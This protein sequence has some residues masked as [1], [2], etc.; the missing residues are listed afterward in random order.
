MRYSWIA[1]ACSMIF[2]VDGRLLIMVFIANELKLKIGPPAHQIA[3]NPNINV[4]IMDLVCHVVYTGHI[5]GFLKATHRKFNFSSYRIYTVHTG[6]GGG[7]AVDFD[8]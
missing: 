7:G 3:T 6:G 8:I 5:I 2:Y 1:S 4:L